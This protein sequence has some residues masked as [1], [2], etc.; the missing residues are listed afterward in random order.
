[1]I[2]LMIKN[3]FENDKRIDSV[4]KY[5]NKT[6]KKNCLQILLVTATVCVIT[7][8]VKAHEERIDE[9]EA[10]LEVIKSKLT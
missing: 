3:I 10:E 5:V 8:T 9:L 1:M 7:A 6:N 2:D 4:I